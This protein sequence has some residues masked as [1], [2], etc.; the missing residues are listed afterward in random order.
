MRLWAGLVIL[1]AGSYLIGGVDKRL[2]LAAGLLR[3]WWPWALLALAA[4]N[5]G[6][7]IVRSES[8]IAP[9]LIALAAIIGLLAR[10]PEAVSNIINLAIPGALI[11]IGTLLALSYGCRRSD[12][13]VRVLTSA[14][15]H[16][17]DQIPQEITVWA[18]AG[19]LRLD[20][21]GAGLDTT[22]EVT[23]AVKVIL[24]HVHLDVPRNWP[25]HLPADPRSDRLVLTKIKDIGVRD[26]QEGDHGATLHLTGFCGAV[27]LLRH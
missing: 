16:I 19:E 9:G 20:F 21:A 15:V 2:E 23:I 4:I 12:R 7:T 5:L 17:H 18:I 8:L 13:W 25:I 1:G 24:G 3:S 10:R 27:T 26:Q 11:L 14:R 22:Q 6:R